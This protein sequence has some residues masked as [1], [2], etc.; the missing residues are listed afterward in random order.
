MRK[1][2]L[3]VLF[4]FAVVGLHGCS[5]YKAANAPDFKDLSVLK[6]GNDRYKVVG[7]LGQPVLTE[8]LGDGTKVDV[9]KFIQGQHKAARAG[10]G[11]YYGMAAV[12]SLG[13]SEVITTPLEGAVG[14]GKEIQLKV[15]YDKDDRV[16]EI[17]VLRDDRWFPFQIIEE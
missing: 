10:R 17:Q 7:E 4:V 2:L 6:K 16:D 15:D 1:L 14:R 8:S 5:S 11:V 12:V 3:T 9:F 13:L